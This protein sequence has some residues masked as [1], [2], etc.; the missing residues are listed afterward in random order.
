MILIW[1]NIKISLPFKNNWL[2]FF[3]KQKR[4]NFQIRLKLKPPQ[5]S[6]II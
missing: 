2:I 4:T 1:F 3:S 5:I 6:W